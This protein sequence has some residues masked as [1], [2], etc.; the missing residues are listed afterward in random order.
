AN[1][2]QFGTLDI[3]D[4]ETRDEGGDCGQG[5]PDFFGD[6]FLDQVRVCCNAGGHFTG[7]QA[8][9]IGHVLSQDGLKIVFTDLLRDMLASVDESNGADV[10]RDK[11]TD[12]E[13][14]KV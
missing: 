12:T 14:H 8:I 2:G 1:S 6:T 3:G 9:E 4:D 13:V 7:T 10:D 5:Q 11:F